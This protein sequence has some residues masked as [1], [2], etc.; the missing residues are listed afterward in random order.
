MGTMTVELSDLGG[1]SRQVSRASGDLG[2]AEDYARSHISDGDFGRILE[3]IT[4]DYEALIST[5]HQALA[6]DS[7]RL[8][9]FSGALSDHRVDMAETDRQVAQTFGVGARI[10]DDG[11]ASGFSD[12]ARPQLPG[13][14]SAGVELPEV[15]FGFMLDKCCDLIVWVGGPDPREYVTKWIA[16][17][18]GKAS[19]QVQAWDHLSACVKQVETNLAAGQD[20]ISTTWRGLA[21]DSSGS[22]MQ[23]WVSSLGSQATGC[24]SMSGH[25]TD[26][27]EQSVQM[28]QVV[29]DI[30]KT[31]ISIV[32]AALSSAYIPGWGQWKAIKTVKEAITLVNNARKVITMFWNTITMIKDYIITLV[33]AFSMTELP[34]APAGLR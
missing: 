2:N 31:V 10:T 28:A 12:Q 3:L 4:G 9:S 19:L 5:F 17:D 16:G 14:S 11:D 29:V 7:Q 26:M 25:L 30:I 18:I 34:P 22:Q 27:I 6:T 33:N 23:A 1:W 32:S 8:G 13:P 20:A 15:S 24:S 21:A